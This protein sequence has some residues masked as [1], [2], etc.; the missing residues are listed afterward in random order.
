MSLGFET[1][2]EIA[3]VRSC[4]S[5]ENKICIG[6]FVQSLNAQLQIIR[7]QSQC[8]FHLNLYISFGVFSQFSRK[9]TS[10]T[11][12]AEPQSSKFFFCKNT[13]NFAKFE[14]NNNFTLSFWKVKKSLMFF[15]VKKVALKSNVTSRKQFED[16]NVSWVPR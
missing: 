5:I 13:L 14:H 12:F 6:R 16:Q 4:Y 3:C 1:T 11:S 9:G 7:L 8:T 2:S 10:P 15:D